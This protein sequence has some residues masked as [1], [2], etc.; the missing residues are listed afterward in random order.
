MLTRAA[1]LAGGLGE[2]FATRISRDAA[3]QSATLRETAHRPWP[4]PG[5]PWLQGQ[6]WCDLL[7]AHWAVDPEALR[8]ALPAELPLDT[9]DGQAWIG[10]TP[11]ELR[12]LRPHGMVP[13]PLISPFPE[14][15][16]R[17][18]MTIDGRPGIWFLSLDAASRLAVTAAR[19][20]YRLPYHHA[21]M[22]IDRVGRDVV[23]RTRR[24]DGAAR[25]E[26]RYRPTGGG[27]RARPGSLEHFLTERYCLYTVDERHRV[28]RA[29]IHHPPW[30]LRH[31][32]AEIGV[33]TMT[34]PY[35]IELPHAQPL[36][37]FAGRQDVLI[38]PLQVVG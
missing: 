13:P 29:D 32:T 36:L 10:I 20:A 27:F 6:T 14:T 16:V 7:F 1:H 18:Y 15:N 25:L 24:Y 12:G 31:A 33:N 8:P 30:P 22:G 37:H 26:L 9:F 21:D 11:F 38:W 34:A 19:R 35:G 23:Y 2:A 4:A 28:K 5:G 3:A 17:T